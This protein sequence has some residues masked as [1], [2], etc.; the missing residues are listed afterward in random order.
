MELQEFKL[1]VYPLKDRL[2]RQALFMLKSVEEAEDTLQDVMLK[3]WHKREQL[4]GYTSVE[5]YAVT[6]TRNACLDKLKTK[7]HKNGFDIQEMELDSG[8]LTAQEKMEQMQGASVMM[9]AFDRLPEQQRKLILL[10]EVEGFSYE[11]ISE[12]TGLEVN[13]IRVA[14][15]RARK[16]ARA[17]YLKLV[18]YEQSI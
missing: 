8:V 14:L 5:A 11:E 17:T 9:Q 12:Q 1:K 10:R 15:S 2:Y 6:M 13:N 3:L 4:I 18:N 16:A 7:K